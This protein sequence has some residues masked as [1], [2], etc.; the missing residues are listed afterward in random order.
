[1]SENQRVHAYTRVSSTGQEDGYSLDTQ[2]AACRR[3]ATE[4]GLTV[5]SVAREVW[6]GGDRHRPELDALLDRLTP[7]DVVLAYALDRMS[8]SQIDTAILIDRIESAGARLELVTEDFERSATG[9]FLRNAKAFVAELE[10]E[11]IRERTTR[12]KAARVAGGKYPAVGRPPYGY[13]WR[14]PGPKQK[15]QLVPNEDTAPIVQRIFRDVAAGTSARKLA[16]AL[17]ASGV[18]T[19]TGRGIWIIPTIVNMIRHPAYVGDLVANRWKTEKVYGKRRIQ[20]RLPPEDHVIFTDA[21]PALVSRDLA[22]TAQAQLARN[23]IEAVRNNR[24]PEAALLRGGFARCG[25]CGNTLRVSS[26]SNTYACNM[27]NHDRYGCPSFAIMT[28]I[29]DQAIW[30]KVESVLTRPEVIAAELARLRQSDPVKAD[31][32]TIDRRTTEI[33]RKQ[34]NLIDRLADTDDTDVAALIQEDLKAIA[35]Q[36]RQLEAERAEAEAQ[37]EA[38]QLAQD[39][40]AD[41]DAWRRKVAANLGSISYEER[42]LALRALG[43]EAKVWRSDHDPRFAITMQLDLIVDSTTHR[44]NAGKCRTG[45]AAT[46]GRWAARPRCYCGPPAGLSAVARLSPAGTGS[47]PPP[48]P[49]RSPLASMLREPRPHPEVWP[50]SSWEQGSSPSRRRGSPRRSAPATGSRRVSCPPPR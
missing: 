30:S 22:T 29:L 33:S 34:R 35:A 31:V 19:A 26:S 32:V 3:W 13:R 21:I 42:R 11:K 24:N 7:G 36:K 38:W 15:T 46:R 4:R 45:A 23:K 1:M 47:P 25:Y 8:R 16:M 48:A 43:V 28:H 12:G 40:L 27:S 20:R 5:A 14:D 6:S 37:R 44:C 18:P 17:N 10:R 2:E 49:P 9:T 50:G 41:L 39:R